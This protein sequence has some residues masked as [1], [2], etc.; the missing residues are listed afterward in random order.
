LFKYFFIKNNK[1][2]SRYGSQTQVAWACI[3]WQAQ[4]SLVRQC[5]QAKEPIKNKKN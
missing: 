4:L 5:W 3:G 1:K 2:L